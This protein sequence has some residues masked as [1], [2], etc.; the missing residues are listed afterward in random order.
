[1]KKSEIRDII[2]EALS[3]LISTSDIGPAYVLT[4]NKS[5]VT[6][7]FSQHL[8]S[9]RKYNSISEANA[10]MKKVAEKMTMGPDGRGEPYSENKVPSVEGAMIYTWTTEYYTYTEISCPVDKVGELISDPT[11]K[12]PDISAG[13]IEHMV[14]GKGKLKEI[15]GW[16]KGPTE[17]LEDELKKR[18]FQ[19]GYQS[20]LKGEVEVRIK[21]LSSGQSTVDILSDKQMVVSLPDFDKVAH[22]THKLLRDHRGN[23][24][25][26]KVADLA[27]RLSTR[28]KSN[29]PAK[30]A[31]AEIIKTM[32][33]EQVLGQTAPTSATLGATTTT[34]KSSPSD[35]TDSQMSDAD[36]SKISSLQT[37]QGKLTNDVRDL[38]GQITKLQEPVKRQVQK[39]ELKKADSQK[40]LGSVTNQITDINKKYGK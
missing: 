33:K 29:V 15:I 3:E 5:P 12:L 35:Q 13:D 17:G 31:L 9:A 36:T 6:R 7:D 2:R 11:L 26:K 27:D 32:L 14:Q 21:K 25:V 40:K 18:G 16:Y 4:F 28:E 1:M 20:Y 19:K 10:S 38:D 22:H 39:L 30:T 37:Q 34:D 24:D 8:Y 23:Y